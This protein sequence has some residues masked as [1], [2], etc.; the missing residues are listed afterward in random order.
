MTAHQQ[1]AQQIDKSDNVLLAISR[2]AKIDSTVSA[3]AAKKFLESVG[4]KATLLCEEPAWPK[5]VSFLGEPKFAPTIGKKPLVISVDTS[6]LG[7]GALSYEAKDG[8]L[9]IF[10]ESDEGTFAP[11]DVRVRE[12]SGAHDLIM[13][14]GVTDLRHV[15]K[16]FLENPAVF[17][18]TPIINVDSSS[19]NEGYGS[20]QLV[21]ITNTST[22]ELTFSLLESYQR[23]MVDPDIATHLLTGIIAQTNCFRV[24]SITPKTLKA[25]ADLVKLDADREKIVSNLYRTRT[26][27]V[28]KLWGRALSRL[29][30]DKM[31]HIA[32]SRV[33]REDF[34]QT[35][36]SVEHLL[37]VVDE[38]IVNL[39]SLNVVVIFFEDE[40]KKVRGFISLTHPAIRPSQLIK[41]ADLS[42]NKRF[43]YFTTSFPDIPTAERAIIDEVRRNYQA[44]CQEN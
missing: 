13:T 31:N 33:H 35:E 7:P 5:K 44:I 11:Q 28:L 6:R 37:D 17:Y 9:E 43:A 34:L 38:I 20:V 29:E 12:A 36:T 16:A 18:D 41:S 40:N 27:P 14:F 1:A 26:L 23:E 39:P 25:A 10:V 3:L 8:Q 4:K 15:G 42:G 19:D 32:W 2:N 30:H 21:D 22:S 24:A